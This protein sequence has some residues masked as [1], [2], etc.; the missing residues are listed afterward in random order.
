MEEV[1]N[2]SMYMTP[3]EF[4]NQDLT[5][6]NAFSLLHINCRSLP[7][8]YD[9]ITSVLSTL[10][11]SFGLVAFS[12]TWLD[13]KVRKEFYIEGYNVESKSRNDRRG[14]GVA[15]AIRHDIRYIVRNDISV[16]NPLCESLFIEVFKPG[17]NVI[18]GVFL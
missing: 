13:T 17:K 18:V 3:E 7:K 8:H 14:G 5:K 12:E 9:D 4:L 16:F 1:E 2:G 6:S 10:E 11:H 15:F